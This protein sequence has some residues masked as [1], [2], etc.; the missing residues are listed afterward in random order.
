MAEA[1]AFKDGIESA[2]EKNGRGLYW[3][4]IHMSCMVLCLRNAN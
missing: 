4:Q 1:M 3:K 2:I